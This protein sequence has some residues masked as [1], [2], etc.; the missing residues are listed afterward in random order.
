MIV[1]VSV[2]VVILSATRKFSLHF[3][4][5]LACLPVCF[6]VSPFLPFPDP[7]LSISSRVWPLQATAS[8]RLSPVLTS[9]LLHLDP[10]ALLPCFCRTS[11]PRLY[12]FQA[13]PHARK[14]MVVSRAVKRIQP[15]FIL[16]SIPAS[17][18]V[19]SCGALSASEQCGVVW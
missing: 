18:G 14:V 8:S 4:Y 6:S 11:A 19:A 12:I 7:F 13:P 10:M 16:I 9:F 3:S 5:F 17:P 1:E 2:G 15:F